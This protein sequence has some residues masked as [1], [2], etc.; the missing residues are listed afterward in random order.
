[1]DLRVDLNASKKRQI[2]AIPGI[3]HGRPDNIPS[4]YRLSESELFRGLTETCVTKDLLKSFPIMYRVCKSIF[5]DG[6]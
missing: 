1:M 6:V 4:P 2:L 5:E 3:E